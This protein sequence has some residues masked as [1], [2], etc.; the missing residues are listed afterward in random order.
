LAFVKKC[1]KVPRTEKNIKAQAKYVFKNDE[2]EESL[3]EKPI[4]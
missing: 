1:K 2:T 4:N 3:K